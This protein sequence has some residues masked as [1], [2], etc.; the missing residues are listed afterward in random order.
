M[1]RILIVL[2]C[3]F[4]LF[5]CKE[6]KEGA[7]I[8]SGKIEHATGK[9]L[10]LEELPYTG[11]APVIID[12]TSL[13]ENGNFELRGPGK[14]E[15][16][17]RINIAEGPQLFFVNDNNRIQVRYDVNDYR[18]PYFSGSD[19]SVELYAFVNQFLKKDDE[20]RKLSQSMQGL[21]GTGN[22]SALEVIKM[23]GVAE[24]KSL[25]DLVTAT[26]NKTESP[27]VAYFALN[28]GMQTMNEQ[29]VFKMAEAIAKRFPQH[30]GIAVVKSK[31]A[32]TA[33]QTNTGDNYA[34][35]N[36]QAP[37]LQMPDTTG[38][39]FSLSQLK[40]KY[41]LV[42]FWASWCAPCRKENPNVVAAFNK[43]KNKNFT[44]VGVSLDSDKE[45]WVK[46]IKDDGLNWYHMSDL[47]QWSSAAVGAYGFDGIPFNVL[48]DTTGKIIASGLRGA[49][50]EKKLTEVIK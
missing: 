43:Y 15:T 10:Y 3:M 25:N 47:K 39:A 30:N 31:L 26:A 4:L 11:D 21:I 28:R 18:N 44:I 19:A 45:S 2:G 33:A 41:V 14:E 20:L 12:S 42:D 35:L 6:K 27:A 37:D 8:I 22:D 1:K 13:K 9:K 40:G 49:E 38:A 7:F 16:L 32:V 5:S 34:L 24:M 50:L 36:K 48:L 17:Y 29:E 23:K 46:A